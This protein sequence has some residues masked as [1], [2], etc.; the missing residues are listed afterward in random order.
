[1]SDPEEIKAE[2]EIA[3]AIKASNSRP[4]DEAISGLG[5]SNAVLHLT[6][7]ATPKPQ[8]KTTLNA[9]EKPLLFTYFAIQGLGE[10]PRL[11]LAEAQM[12]HEHIA[13]IGAEDQAL[14]LEWRARSPNGLLPT[15]SGMG[16]GRSEPLS[17]ST[18]IIHFLGKRLGM[19]GD[20]SDVGSARVNVLYETAKDLNGKKDDIIAVDATKDYSVAKGAFALGKRIEK[21][22]SIMNDPKDEDAAMNFGQI[23]LFQYLMGMEARRPGCV[24]ENL[25]DTLD[26]FRVNM[27]ERN[28]LKQYLASTARFPYTHGDLGQDGGYTYAAGTLTRGDIKY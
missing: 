1:M 2:A 19:N 14:A 24:K 12:P 5:P 18:A 22:L 26:E 17:Q 3:A 15:L 16:I 28:G 6:S 13:V 20:G 21:M 27:G 23:Q 25:G 4:K 9:D 7:T 11:M 8:Y 10:V